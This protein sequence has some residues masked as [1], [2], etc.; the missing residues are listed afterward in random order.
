VLQGI[1]PAVVSEWC[2]YHFRITP[3]LR[4]FDLTDIRNA[5]EFALQIGT[6]GLQYQFNFVATK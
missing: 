4:L 2:Q 1:A 5:A 3:Q 6:Q